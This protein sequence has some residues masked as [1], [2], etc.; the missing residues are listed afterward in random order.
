MCK[1]GYGIS[2]F[3][4]AARMDIG[5]F[6]SFS[7]CLHCSLHC[8]FSPSRSFCVSFV[9]VNVLHSLQKSTLMRHFICKRHCIIILC[10]NNCTL[11]IILSL[12]ESFVP[13]Y[14]DLHGQMQP[15][16]RNWFLLPGCIWPYYAESHQRLGYTSV[17]PSWSAVVYS[18]KPYWIPL[19]MAH[20]LWFLHK[21]YGWT[22]SLLKNNGKM[23]TNLFVKKEIA[24]NIW[25]LKT[26][27]NFAIV[28]TRTDDVTT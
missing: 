22:M 26:Q 15:G 11:E 10:N 3:A 16:K 5:H 20:N 24:H 14:N 27:A 1:V 12:I 19:M 4:A 17:R 23:L 25:Q 28:Y 6:V 9:L 2:N 18:Q 21:K 7:H 13:N 8:W